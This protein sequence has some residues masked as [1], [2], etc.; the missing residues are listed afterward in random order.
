MHCFI[1]GGLYTDDIHKQ[2]V[3]FMREKSTDM[4]TPQVMVL[5]EQDGVH[6]YSYDR[7]E[8]LS[9]ASLCR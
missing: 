6:F 3:A 7:D 1:K 8:P 2:V 5:L 4:K 9:D